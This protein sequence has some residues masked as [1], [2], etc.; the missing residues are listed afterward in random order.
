[1]DKLQLLRSTDWHD[2]PVDDLAIGVHGVS[3]VVTPFDA[4]SGAHRNLRL[5]INA[6]HRLEFSTTFLSAADL[7]RLEV[8]SFT[9][10]E[11]SGETLSGRLTIL[12]GSAGIWSV[13]F[14]G[15]TWD[16]AEAPSASHASAREKRVSPSRVRA[17]A[18]AL[19]FL[20]AV[21][22]SLLPPAMW[23]DMVMPME[24]NW[25]NWYWK[26]QPHPRPDFSLQNLPP[27]FAAE[28]GVYKALVIPPAYLARA[29]TGLPTAY[30]T[31]WVPPYL[32]TAGIPPLALAA[33]HIKWAVPMWFVATIALY[34]LLYGVAARIKRRY[35]AA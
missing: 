17:A 3:L 7:T 24:D 6:P 8:S 31:M 26:G 29:V 5:V 2:L 19:C 1:M 15:A 33:G 25:E 14:R 12:P 16:L 20:T 23:A 18:Y 28:V 9:V 22:L 10:K 35:S 27:L 13:E 32:E 30:G 34:E 11:D 21:V 4:A